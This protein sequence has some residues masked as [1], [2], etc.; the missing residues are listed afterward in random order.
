MS[1]KQFRI[2]VISVSVLLFFFQALR[3]AFST[4]FG[5]IYDQIFEGPTTAFLG[6]AVGALTPVPYSLTCW[7][8]GTLELTLR[9]IFW[10]NLLRLPRF[11]V[12]YQA[13]AHSEHLIRLFM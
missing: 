1:L 7:V 6:V 5:I 12:L 9:E 2:Q 11:L 13:F 8:A 4:L 10:V 3:V